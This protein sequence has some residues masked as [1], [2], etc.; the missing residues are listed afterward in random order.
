MVGKRVGAGQ[1][2]AQSRI[3]VIVTGDTSHRVWVKH[4]VDHLVQ[5]ANWSRFLIT[6]ACNPK[7]TSASPNLIPNPHH[8]CSS[9]ALVQS[10][11][12]LVSTPT[13]GIKR[14]RAVSG[15]TIT[16]ALPTTT[17]IKER[18]THRVS[19][20]VMQGT[21]NRNFLFGC[22]HYNQFNWI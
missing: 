15:R 7:I 10:I 4:R 22:K 12:H 19:S 6:W 17:A 5:S 9:I 14:I 20:N 13:S 11:P 18:A 8:P 3:S 2:C 16:A 21:S 1:F